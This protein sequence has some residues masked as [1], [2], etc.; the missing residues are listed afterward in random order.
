MLVL[1]DTKF[2]I[3][4]EYDV[5]SFFAKETIAMGIGN[6]NGVA[7]VTLTGTL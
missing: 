4:K 2:Y 3:K 5:I 6:V 7:K 1:T